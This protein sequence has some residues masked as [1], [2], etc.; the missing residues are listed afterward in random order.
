MRVAH[1]RPHCSSCLHD[2]IAAMSDFTSLDRAAEFLANRVVSRLAQV[3]E[4]LRVALLKLGLDGRTL[5]GC[6][7]HTTSGP[8]PK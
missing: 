8:P 6:T 1:V 7:M 5:A 4:A 2:R 3:A